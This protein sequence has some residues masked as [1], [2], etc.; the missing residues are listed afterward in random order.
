MWGKKLSHN[1]NILISPRWELHADGK[2][3]VFYYGGCTL[4][5]WE[6]MAWDTSE[7]V[8]KVK[9]KVTHVCIGAMRVGSGRGGSGWH[10]RS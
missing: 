4:M 9:M 1:G 2:K 7:L 6:R 10:L 5:G 8:G 3:W